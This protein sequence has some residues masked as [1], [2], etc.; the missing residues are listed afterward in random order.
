M[1]LSYRRACFGSCLV[2]SALVG[3]DAL[4][5]KWR[6]LE[7][8]K[9]LK[10]NSEKEEFEV[11]DEDLL[12]HP[13]SHKVNLWEKDEDWE[14]RKIKIRGSLSK[15]TQLVYREKNGEKGYLL[16]KAL[17]TASQRSQENIPNRSLSNMGVPNGVLVNIGWV[18]HSKV[19]QVDV[20]SNDFKG[21]KKQDEESEKPYLFAQVSDPATGFLYDAKSEDAE[22][23]REN[24]SMEEVE[25][26]GFLR[27]GEDDNCLIGQKNWERE[28]KTGKVDLERMASFFN[29]NNLESCAK[30]YVQLSVNKKPEQLEEEAIRPLSL[31]GV[32]EEIALF[33]QREAYRWNVIRNLSLIGALTA[34]T[35]III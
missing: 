24:L 3:S 21:I 26:V 34:L 8:E 7:D 17:L 4:S 11:R 33:C 15:T 30:Y 5:K 1:N 12:I 6:A 10:L 18:P 20:M 35:G 19:R 25:L 2:I 22:L 32:K 9:R 28:N 13:W 23:S 16:F 14:F 27:K 29:F 31:Y